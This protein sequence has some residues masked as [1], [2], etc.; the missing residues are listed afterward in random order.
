MS[1]FSYMAVAG[2]TMMVALRKATVSRVNCMALARARR[3]L[4][5]GGGM[6]VSMPTGQRSL[7]LNGQGKRTIAHSQMNLFRPH[8]IVS[9]DQ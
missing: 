6:K 2:V 3:E 1:K 5:T 4:M 7:E 8:E 9:S